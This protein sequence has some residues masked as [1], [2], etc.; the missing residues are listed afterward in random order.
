MDKPGASSLKRPRRLTAEE[1]IAELS[2]DQA[3]LHRQQEKS[4][5]IEKLEDEWQANFMPYLTAINRS[6]YQGDTLGDILSHNSPL[7]STIV[8]VL[9]QAVGE[10]H[11]PRDVEMVVRA[12]AASGAPYDGTALANVFNTTDDESLKWACVNTIAMTSPTNLDEW[13]GTLS[14][15]WS[16]VLGGCKRNRGK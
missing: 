15:Y 3:Y 10:L 13:M 8:S 9:L 14:E 5:R 16:D 11:N 7:D 1:V 6:G 12:L 4:R 2:R